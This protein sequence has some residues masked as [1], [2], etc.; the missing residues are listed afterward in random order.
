MS[1][2][3]TLNIFS[4]GVWFA[5]SAMFFAVQGAVLYSV[6]GGGG[7]S[8]KQ[9]DPLARD[10]YEVSNKHVGRD[11]EFLRADYESVSRFDDID[12]PRRVDFAANILVSDLL[13]PGERAPTGARADAFAK[14]RAVVYAGEE[15]RRV[16]Q[17]LARECEVARADGEVRDG[18]LQMRASLKFVQQAEFGEL[19]KR[20]DYAFAPLS[21][22]LK[23]SGPRKTALRAEPAV[24]S[25]LYKKAAAECAAIRRREGNC[26]ITDL[27]IHA[28]LN[29]RDRRSVVEGSAEF[30]MLS[31]ADGARVS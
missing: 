7:S 26:A 31:A 3:R 28:R 22:P 18:V 9:K 12:A 15:C 6:Y 24:R 4:R 19:D 29:P 30:G 10:G 14:A 1:V 13:E 11:S 16:L 2:L 21:E 20:R 23:T 25:A 5:A 27:D 17:T 8:I